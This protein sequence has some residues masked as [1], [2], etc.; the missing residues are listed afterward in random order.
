MNADYQIPVPILFNPLKHHLRFQRGFINQKAGEPGIDIKN[1]IKE[2]RHLGASVMDVYSGSITVSRIC[3]EVGE[4]L[5]Q[6][7]ISGKEPFCNWTGSEKSNFRIT[8]LSDGSQWTLKYYENDLRFVHIFPARN[9]RHT[10]RV[11]ANTLKPAILFNIVSGKDFISTDELNRVRV[12][13]NLSP[14]KDN[15]DTEAITEMIEILRV[16]D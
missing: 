11:K 3:M 1:L 15:V 2:L 4:F 12:L 14:V 10:F 7:G 5:N 16:S 8:S 13:L 6:K 9:S